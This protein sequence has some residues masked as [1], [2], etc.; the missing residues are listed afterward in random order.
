M[1]QISMMLLRFQE[2]HQSSCKWNQSVHQAL[3]ACD[4]YGG[5]YSGNAFQ[6]K[7]N[8]AGLHGTFNLKHKDLKI[9]VLNK[10]N[11]EKKGF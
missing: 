11:H 1:L 3:S 6:F 10:N 9:A 2:N 5:N 4:G 8:P 7:G